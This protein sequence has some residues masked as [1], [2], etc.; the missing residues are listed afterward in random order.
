MN[1]YSLTKE[2]FHTVI[3]VSKNNASFVYFTLESHE[4]LA[5]YSTLDDSLPRD[6]RD[7]DLKTPIEFEQD[8]KHLLKQLEQ[9]FEI[10][11]LSEAI[12][13]DS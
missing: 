1:T 11:V 3:R 12:L 9:K 5:F 4:G 8:L 10:I 7:I 6:Y 2:L 13:K